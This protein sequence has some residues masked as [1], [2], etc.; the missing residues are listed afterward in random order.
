[1][2]NKKEYK[3]S[4]VIKQEE[5]EKAQKNVKSLDCFC[6]QAEKWYFAVDHFYTFRQG[7]SSNKRINEI[8]FNWHQYKDLSKRTHIILAQIVPLNKGV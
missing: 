7:T 1:M 3:K 4:S 6:H 8:F 5:I 2:R